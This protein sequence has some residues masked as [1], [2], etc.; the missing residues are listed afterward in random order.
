MKLLFDIFPVVLFFAT[1]KIADN[2]YLATGVAIAASLAQVGYTYWK[3]KKVEPI[4]WLSLAVIVVFGGATL[5]FHDETFIKW[6]PTV[7]YWATGVVLGGAA[8]LFRKNLI[9]MAMQDKVAPPEHFWGRLLLAW[10][11]FLAGMGALNL[12]VAYNFSTEFWVGFK[13]LGG[14]GLLLAFALGQG[15]FLARYV[16]PDKETESEE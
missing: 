11:A 3:H 8:L 9:R 16:K 6:K 4:M 15:L 12:A 1:Y 5:L 7:L 13:L 10:I 2:I 14:I